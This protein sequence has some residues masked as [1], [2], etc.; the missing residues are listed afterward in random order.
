M[1]YISTRGNNQ[2]MTSAQ[3]IIAGLAD[4]GGLF[5]PEELPQVDM[6]FIKGLIGLSYQ[7]RAARVLGRFLTDYTEE[8]IKGC[9]DRAYGDGKFDD[10]AVAPLN[11]M[12]DVSVLELWH[13]PTSAFK[14]MALQLLPQLLSTALKKTGEKIRC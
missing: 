11:I 14:D 7:E 9:V 12:E 2:R 3:A 5:V 13:G 4:D 8:E 10:A 6:E 1:N